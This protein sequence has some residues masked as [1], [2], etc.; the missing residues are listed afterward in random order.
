MNN[1]SLVDKYAPESLDDIAGN[2]KKIKKIK[3]W[4]ENWSLGDS[5]ILLYGEPGVGKTT[6]ARAVANDMTWTSIEINASDDKKTDDIRDIAQQMRSQ[7]FETDYHLFILDEVDS[8]NRRVSLNPLLQILDDPP[9]PIIMTCNEKWK[10]PDS[11]ENRVKAHKFSLDKDDIKPVLK[12]IAIIEDIDVDSRQLGKFATRNG[13]RDAINDLQ[14][15][16]TGSGEVGWDERDTDIGA[17]KAVDNV[18]RGKKFTGEMNPPDMVEWFDENVSSQF[19]GVEAMRAY[20][21]LSEADHWLELTNTTQNYSW[22]RYAGGI[23]EEVAN[24]RVTEPYDGYIPKSYPSSRRQWV[25]RATSD[26][27]TSQLYRELKNFDLPN[28]TYGFNFREF[29]LEILPI[30]QELPK[31]ERFR[32]ILEESLSP[33]AYKK[34]NISK[35]EYQSWLGET[36]EIEENDEE[37]VEDTEER[38][39]FDF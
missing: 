33:S 6:T 22:W 28:F 39:V 25:P 38:G 4:A 34:L 20:Q 16:A 18:L 12:E 7:S 11:I 19:E 10:V 2:E 9:N 21:A 5:A 29:R 35:G 14:Y 13:L 37:S 3:K 31:E 24:L 36:S 17:F 1:Q 30:L 8:Y 27:A 26:N 15:Y 32:I 23:A